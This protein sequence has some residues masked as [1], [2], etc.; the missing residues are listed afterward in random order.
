MFSGKES[1]FMTKIHVLYSMFRWDGHVGDHLE[2]VSCQT[3][4]FL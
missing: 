1:P 4:R 2:V 3:P